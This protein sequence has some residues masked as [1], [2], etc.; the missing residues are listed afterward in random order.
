MYTL[1]DDEEGEDHYED[2]RR[3][4]EFLGGKETSLAVAGHMSAM[5]TSLYAGDLGAARDA[6][7]AAQ[8]ELRRVM[9][10][11]ERLASTPDRDGMIVG[12]E[13]PGVELTSRD[14]LSFVS[15][16]AVGKTLKSHDLLEYW[17]SSPYLFEFMDAYDVK[18][19]LE[20]AAEGPN[21]ALADA[22]R[23]AGDRLSWDDFVRYQPLDPGNAKM[24]GLVTDV[25]DRGAWKLAWI[26][27][28]LPYYEL[29]GAYA[30][31]ALRSFTKRLVFSSWTVVPKTIGAV[32]SYEAERRLLEGSAKT[33]RAYDAP[34]ATALLTFQLT[35]GRL[36]GMP[37]LGILY[38]SAALARAGDPLRIAQELEA[39]FPMDRG[40]YLESV[41]TNVRQLL[42]RLP[43]GSGSGPSD[44]KWYWAAPL[45]LE[46]LLA[47]QLGADGLTWGWEGDDDED[48]HES[49]FQQHVDQAVAINASDLGRQPPDLLDVL[50]YMAAGAPG[51]VALRSLSRALSAD[52]GY[53]NPHL[54][55]A[56]SDIAWAFRGLFNRPEIMAV[57]RGASG[58][59]EPYWQSVLRHSID[60]GLQSV[61]DEYVHVLFES[62]GLMDK[63][64][65]EQ[66]LG[67]A[68]PIFEAL[69]LRASNST[70]HFF[71]AA[72]STVTIDK[73][74]RLRSHFAVRFGRG[75]AEDT[76]N[77]QRETQVREAYNSPFW[78]FILASTSVG[79]EGLDF[80]QYCHAILHWNLPGN[81]VDLEQRE[82]RV[83][84]YKGHAVRKNVAHAYGG[85]PEV[86][87]SDDP[88]VRMFQLAAADR[89]A[90]ES[91]IFPYWVFTGASVI[92]RYTPVMPMSKETHALGRLMRTVGAYRLVIGQPRQED[93]LRYLGDK[94]DQLDDLRIDLTPTPPA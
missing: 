91:E 86:V 21:V 15:D 88:W 56:A 6:K 46:R 47:D 2:F 17:R 64:L 32:V 72:S 65:E 90:G 44:D 20:V 94:A 19:R 29:G 22:L 41:R 63:P 3:T 23:L 11:T 55:N 43:A 39:T 52:D 37:V 75:T 59:N 13:L 73:T 24:R 16:S 84:R 83:H 50:T 34:R 40:T 70:V 18:K 27:P 4:V 66:T 42:T 1:P 54:R 30:D 51:T 77:V 60:G 48:G 74:R 92:E 33:Q 78:P 26:P 62:Q 53:L 67:F 76:Q 35:D 7:D 61:L 93:L 38:P 79:Q 31:A 89:P 5:R 8:S 71:N 10:R 58:E 28:S 36:T 81:P 87:Q 82:G 49:R 9:V 80:H 57:V 12:K 68:T 25:L 69:S 14:V 45:L 85:R